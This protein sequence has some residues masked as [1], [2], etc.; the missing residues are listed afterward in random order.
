[1]L[2]WLCG[3][4]ECC[5]SMFGYSLEVLLTL[6]LRLAEQLYLWAPPPP[7]Q[8]A[9]SSPLRSQCLQHP[10]HLGKDRAVKSNTVSWAR[11]VCV[12]VCVCAHVGPWPCAG[13]QRVNGQQLPT[14]EALGGVAAALGVSPAALALPGR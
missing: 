13:S 6:S 2:A 8:P 9:L 11:P 1:M 3:F 14:A 4:S 7:P 5:A 10:R 12:C